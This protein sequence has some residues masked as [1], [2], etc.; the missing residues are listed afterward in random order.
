MK[1]LKSNIFY[2]FCILLS[3]L[4]GTVSA[5]TALYPGVFNGD[6]ITVL[7]YQVIFSFLLVAFVLFIRK[8]LYFN[9]KLPPMSSYKKM[10]SGN[11][12]FEGIFKDIL[13]G[14]TEYFNARSNNK[15]INI[16]ELINYFILLL[17]PVT[18]MFLLIRLR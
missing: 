9:F 18:N 14:T 8:C 7:S 1:I 16:I 3:G 11:Y 10:K 5:S 13:D 15:C 12:T 6:E 17:I 2:V 4:I